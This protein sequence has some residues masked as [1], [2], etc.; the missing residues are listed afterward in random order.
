MVGQALGQSTTRVFVLCTTLV[1]RERDCL[2]CFPL[3][4]FLA[5]PEVDG[6]EPC[7]LLTMMALMEQFGTRWEEDAG[8]LRILPNHM[9]SGQNSL[10]KSRASDRATK[11][12]STPLPLACGCLGTASG[13]ASVSRSTSHL[14]THI[15]AGL[16]E[17]LLHLSG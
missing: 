12:D 7:A 17:Q 4:L 9:H 15:G 3:H 5:R 11:L 14:L 10:Q 2:V 1:Q 6:G 8:E 16:Q 13:E